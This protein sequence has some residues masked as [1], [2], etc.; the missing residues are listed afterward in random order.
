MSKFKDEYGND[1]AQKIIDYYP[2]R[3]PVIVKL[4]KDFSKKYMLE[5]S[6]YIVPDDL[7]LGQFVYIIRRKIK[8]EAEKA[9]FVYINN[10]LINNAN[11]I[12]TIYADHKNLDGFL[13]IDLALESTFG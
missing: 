13:Y 5:K 10:K 2:H 1:S 6:K 11:N 8:L 3:I 7:S 9:V 4:S 12:Q